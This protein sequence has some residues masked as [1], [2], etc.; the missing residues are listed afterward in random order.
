MTRKSARTFKNAKNAS[1]LWP[2][3]ILSI[4]SSFSNSYYALYR[5]HR[6]SMGCED[7]VQLRRTRSYPKGRPFTFRPL[8]KLE[9]KPL[10]LLV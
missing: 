7:K 5:T 1:C 4:L 9:S 8:S 2:T 6:L 3:S 10:I